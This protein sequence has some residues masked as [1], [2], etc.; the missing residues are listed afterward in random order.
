MPEGRQRRYTHLLR[1]NQA[2]DLTQR[3]QEQLTPSRD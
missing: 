2:R 3:E 1:K